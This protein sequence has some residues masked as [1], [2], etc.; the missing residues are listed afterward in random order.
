MKDENWTALQDQLE[1]AGMIDRVMLV[2]GADLTPEP[3]RWLWDTGWR[4]ASYTSLLVRLGKV[5][6]P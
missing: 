1:A 2:N 6:P 4:W 5:R 3:V